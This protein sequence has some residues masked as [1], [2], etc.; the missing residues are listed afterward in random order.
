VSSALANRSA[1]IASHSPL[2]GIAGWKNSGK[3]T[4]TCRL[5]EELTRRGRRIATI[6]HAHHTFTID[7]EATDS[8]RH[9]RAGARQVAIVSA[10]RMAVVTELSDQPEPS[11]EAMIARLAPC[12]LI[13]VEGYKRERLPKIEA[14]RTAQLDRRSLAADDPWVVAIASDHPVTDSRLPT[15]GLND[16]GG[17]SDYITAT[18]LAKPTTSAT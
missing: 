2:I 17:L 9:R 3:T 12:D 13:I 16:I 14:R 4:L 15:F 10:A 18:I 1:A 6:K 7:D 5:V 11:L 8:A